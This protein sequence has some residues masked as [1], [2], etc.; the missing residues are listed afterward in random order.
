MRGMR[1]LAHEEMPER[2]IRQHGS[3]RSRDIDDG[4]SC[5]ID[6][7]AP[8]AI[9]PS[10]ALIFFSKNGIPWTKIVDL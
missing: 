5:V 7:D 10:L 4:P 1:T 3:R 2:G 9:R 6:W 8:D